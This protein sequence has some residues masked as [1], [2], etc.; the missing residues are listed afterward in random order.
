MAP[1]DG[2]FA[3]LMETGY[4]GA[5]ASLVAVADGTTSLY[6]SNGGGIIGAGAYPQVRDEALAF[7]EA[8]KAHLPALA[9]AGDTPLPR[10]GRTRFTLVSEDGLFVA[11]AEEAELGEKRHALSPLFLQGHR[12]LAYVRAADEHRR[13]KASS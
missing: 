13:G 8:A 2:V 9:P 11:E 5:V 4:P 1:A 7:L 12:L 3:V 6:F 10:E